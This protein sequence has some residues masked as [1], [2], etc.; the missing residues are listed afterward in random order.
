MENKEVIDISLP[1]IAF[2]SAA[3][4]QASTEKNSTIRTC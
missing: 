2:I 3:V 4:S 1:F